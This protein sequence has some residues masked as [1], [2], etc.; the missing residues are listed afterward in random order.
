MKYVPKP[1][2][3]SSVT[4]SDE[5]LELTELIAKNVHENWSKSRIN[6]GW[7]YGEARDDKNKV[8]PCLVPY[9]ELPEFEKDYDRNTAFETLKLITK[10]GFEI[11]KKGE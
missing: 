1:I 10:L 3:T 8:T 11:K 4:L 9:E 6:E 5:L 2:D 7:K